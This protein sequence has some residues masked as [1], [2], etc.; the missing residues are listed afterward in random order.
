MQMILSDM[1][2]NARVNEEFMCSIFEGQTVYALFEDFVHIFSNTGA[3]RFDIGGELLD[4]AWDIRREKQRLTKNSLEGM[5]KI[6][7]IFYSNRSIEKN[8]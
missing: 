8:R 6:H 5:G 7:S 1:I 3:E 2:M 4:R